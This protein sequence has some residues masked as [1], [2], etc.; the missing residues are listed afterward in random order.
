V[1]SAEARSRLLPWKLFGLILLLAALLRFWHLG[2]A[3]FWVDEMYSVESTMGRGFAHRALPL[4]AV[5]DPMPA[6]FDSAHAAPWWLIWPACVGATTGDTHPPLPYILLRFWCD[7]FGYTDA[8]VRAFSAVASLAALLLLFLIGLELHGRGPA[9]WACLIMALAQPQIEYA[10]EAKHY[11]LLQAMALAACLALVRI[12]KRGG[13]TGRYIW[14]GLTVLAMLFTH[15][16]SIGVIGAL[17]L[18]ALI[19]LRGTERRRAV[20]SILTA[21]FVFAVAWGPSM[22]AQA[23]DTTANV[24][25]FLDREPGFM[26]RWFWRLG[27]LPFRMLNDPLPNSEGISLIF[28]V[29][30]FLPAVMVRRRPDLLLWAIWIPAV[31]LNVALIDLARR[32]WLLA[33]V[34]YTLVAA[35]A[36]YLVLTAIGSS[37]PPRLRHLVPIVSVA[38]CAISLPSTYTQLRIDY[39]RIARELNT[40]AQPGDLTVFCSTTFP[41]DDPRTYFFCVSY[42]ARPL[43]GPALL[44]AHP[45]DATLLKALRSRRHIWVIANSDEVEAFFPG[46]RIDAARSFPD[47][48]YVLMSISW[49]DS[50]S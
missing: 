1:T 8:A 35:P 15:Y 39:R 12:E 19:R 25:F 16:F 46:A 37:W 30:Y 24:N 2:H 32:T 45:P 33:M 34:R 29:I 18:Y 6:V 47:I 5:I 11:A 9:L 10:Q 20:T 3:S 38:C 43:P 31:V 22:L 40:R 21:G 7:L 13:S 41:R 23:R 48:G 50:T 4:D 14:R 17:G 28:G 26:S 36:V 42:Y 44:L 27:A 49:P